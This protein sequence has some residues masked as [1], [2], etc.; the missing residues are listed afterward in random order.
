MTAEGPQFDEKVVVAIGQAEWE[1]YAPTYE[2]H[3]RA[4]DLT[5]RTQEDF[6]SYLQ[7]EEE[8]ESAKV[9]EAQKDGE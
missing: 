8:S 7:A 5:A 2:K 3:L 4:G 6:E 1:R 9:S